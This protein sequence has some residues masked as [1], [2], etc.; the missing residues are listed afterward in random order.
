MYKGK[1]SFILN[2]AVD[3][4]VTFSVSYEEWNLAN[5]LPSIRCGIY[6]LLMYP[7]QTGKTTRIKE[8]MP[9]LR[10]ENYFPI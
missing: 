4:A 9:L 2:G 1:K 8:L 6:R 3:T 7:S 5:V 10:R